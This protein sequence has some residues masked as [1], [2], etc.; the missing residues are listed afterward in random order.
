M[1]PLDYGKRKSDINLRNCVVR[2][3]GFNFQGGFE[4]S[5]CLG[6]L[7]VATNGFIDIGWGMCETLLAVGSIS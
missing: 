4:M 3:D 7:S 6:M 5:L 2:R 1:K